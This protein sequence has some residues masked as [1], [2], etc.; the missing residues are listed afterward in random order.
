MQN[1]YGGWNKDF[2]GDRSAASYFDS[3]PL[4]MKEEINKNAEKIR[5][6]DDMRKFAYH[7]ESKQD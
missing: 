3:L 4:E 2:N 1:T 6:I 7:M 5:S